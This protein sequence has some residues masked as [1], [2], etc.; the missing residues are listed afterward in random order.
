[1]I[2][3]YESTHP[4]HELDQTRQYSPVFEKSGHPDQQPLN[5][6]TDYSSHTLQVIGSG[7][8]VAFGAIDTLVKSGIINLNHFSNLNRSTFEI[9]R[10]SHWS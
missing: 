8:S 6:G 10:S 3:Y 9:D 5:S 7:K 2:L 4:D 1:M